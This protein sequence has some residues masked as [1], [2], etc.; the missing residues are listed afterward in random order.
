MQP[1]GALVPQSAAFAAT[2]NLREAANVDLPGGVAG[3]ATIQAQCFSDGDI[4]VVPLAAAARRS[5]T[6]ACP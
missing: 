3:L 6:I 1:Q 5:T 4:G 2:E